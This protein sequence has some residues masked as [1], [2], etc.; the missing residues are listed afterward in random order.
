M[1]FYRTA[2]DELAG[3]AGK[4]LFELK[5]STEGNVLFEKKNLPIALTFGVK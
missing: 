2:C 5:C 3:F 1:V 4:R